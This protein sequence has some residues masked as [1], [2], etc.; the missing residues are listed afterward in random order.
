MIRRYVLFIFIVMLTSCV[1]PHYMHIYESS[2][3]LDF[4]TGKW[5]V[6]NVDCKLPYTY[7]EGLN[8]DLLE[9]FQKL[10]GDSI[11]SVNK[12]SLKYI[13]NDKFSFEL[14]PMMLET[15]KKT[16]DYDYVVTATAR[17]VRD[18]VPDLV[19][20]GTPVSYHKSESEVCIAVYDV[21]LGARVYFQRVVASVSLDAGD[22]K[23]VFGRSAGNLLYNALAKGLKDLKKNSRK[24]SKISRNFSKGN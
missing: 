4:T 2:K 9:G 23:V 11:Y 8:R 16:T 22:E 14:S 13:S 18:D 24:I 21:S 6:T 17:K 10:R 20:P 19:Y 7:R 1:T 15:L 5:L 12:V 3:G